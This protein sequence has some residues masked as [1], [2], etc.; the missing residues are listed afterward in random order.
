MSID[1]NF[2]REKSA[3]PV[4]EGDGRSDRWQ[5][6]S[7]RGLL[8]LVRGGP[9]LILIIIAGIVSLIDPLFF[10]VGNLANVAT[11]SSLVA[12]IALGQLMV[13]LTRGIDLSQGSCIALS[14]VV[15]ALVFHDYGWSGWPTAFA[16]LATG[17]GVGLLNGFAFVKGKV[18]HP[19]VVTLAMLTIARGV[20]LIL[21][22]GAPIS[23]MPDVVRWTGAGSL[24]PIP[25]PAAIT[26]LLAIAFWVFTK[27]LVWGRWI[28]CFGGD[29][30]AARSLGIPTDRILISVYALS[31]FTAG[32]AA[33]ITAGR[34]NSGY[35]SA[36]QL[37]ELDAVAAV[38][39]GGASFFGGRGDVINAVVGALIIGVVRNGMNLIGISPFYQ[40]VVVGAVIVV[41][42]QLDVLRM[43]LEAQFQSRE[44]LYVR[45]A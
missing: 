27:R 23:G 1:K 41:A 7:L 6:T 11:Q 33:L 16:I 32:V 43:H 18:P 39:I 13:I 5:L 35:P 36:G 44:A 12:V 29:P 9:V 28:Y 25:A 31:G 30:E 34:T 17:L 3:R 19:F 40:L 42:V 20:A 21:S 10:T 2:L 4:A 37:A 45:N 14:T 38:I 24:G 22:H 26:G 8:A 15:G